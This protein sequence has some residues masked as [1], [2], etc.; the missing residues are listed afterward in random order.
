MIYMHYYVI[1]DNIKK[2]P[3]H[4]ILKLVPPNSNAY[5]HHHQMIF[6]HRI[7]SDIEMNIN[8]LVVKKCIVFVRKTQYSCQKKS[9]LF[10]TC[11][12]HIHF[13]IHKKK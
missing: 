10:E 13:K 3:D 4:F 5:N 2:A 11:T 12:E 8:I 6:I 9:F 1:F 7:T